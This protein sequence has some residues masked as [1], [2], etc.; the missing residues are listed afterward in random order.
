MHD[1]VIKGG[2]K[3]NIMSDRVTDNGEALLW[4]WIR[5][6]SKNPG[7]LFF[8][9]QDSDP[10]YFNPHSQMCFPAFFL[11]FNQGGINY[12]NINSTLNY[13]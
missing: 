13:R 10:V 8:Q 9:I 7:L 12:M 6:R 11:S 2:E 3:H 5:I 4:V 1:Q